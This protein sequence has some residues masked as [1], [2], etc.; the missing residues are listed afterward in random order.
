MFCITRTLI[1]LYFVMLVLSCPCHF[2]VDFRDTPR[3]R[4]GAVS[5]SSGFSAEPQLEEVV[6]ENFPVRSSARLMSK[7][8]KTKHFS[9]C[10]LWV[11]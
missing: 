7:F 1:F 5:G 3:K 2:S 10:K 4:A 6:D 9:L 8:T 11:L